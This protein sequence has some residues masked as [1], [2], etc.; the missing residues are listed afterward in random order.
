MFE[1]G[2]T[3]PSMVLEDTAGQDVRIPGREAVLLYFTRSTSCPICNRPGAGSRFPFSPAATTAR[4][5]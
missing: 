4:T 3:A 1:T 5:R 2:S